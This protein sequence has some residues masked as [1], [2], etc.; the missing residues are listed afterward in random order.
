M[1]VKINEKTSIEMY[2]EL[3]CGSK[4]QCVGCAKNNIKI[5]VEKSIRKCDED[6][7]TFFCCKIKKSLL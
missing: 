3:I 5:K 7:L 6:C 4:P 2:K 1:R